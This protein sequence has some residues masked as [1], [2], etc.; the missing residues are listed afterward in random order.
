MKIFINFAFL[1]SLLGQ[2]ELSYYGFGLDIGSSGSGLFINAQIPYN[3]KKI[4]FNGELRFYDIK[5]PNE[6]MVYDP[7]YGTTRTIGGISLVMIPMFA[8]IN[9]YPF[10]DKIQNNFS[11]FFAC[12]G[13]GVFTL[14]GAEEGSFRNRWK[15]TD[16][17]FTLGGFL[18]TGV[19]FNM[20]GQTI[21]SPMVGYE[22][23][24][25][26]DKAD[27]ED[28]YSGMLIHI[29]FNRKFSF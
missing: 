29:S 22:F 24:P 26:K 19:E 7:Y 6:S 5:D 9:Y 20:Y 4:S 23:L 1:S 16:T 18:G 13:G 14:N 17:Q 3:S 10:V 2:F 11:P 21:I 15:N 28:D 27:G 12:R 8:G 25:L